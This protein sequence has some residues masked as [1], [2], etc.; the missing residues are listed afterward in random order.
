MNNIFYL[1][2]QPKLKPFEQICYN[3]HFPVLIVTKKEDHKYCLL[4]RANLTIIPNSEHDKIEFGDNEF[5]V[6][7]KDKE[8]IFEL[9]EDGRFQK[10]I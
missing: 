8:E 5:I 1:L 6:K 7:D 4:N 9:K 10:K 2:F 3:P